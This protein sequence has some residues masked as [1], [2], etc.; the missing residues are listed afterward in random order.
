MLR[1]A[2]ASPAMLT[3]ARAVTARIRA[4]MWGLPC[5]VLADCLRCVVT[6]PPGWDARSV[7][8]EPLG[9]KCQ[10][11]IK[12]IADRYGGNGRQ[13]EHPWMSQARGWP[14]ASNA[15]PSDARFERVS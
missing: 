7:W 11:D 3:V 2:K 12:F 9:R 10:A 5:K 15:R 8:R 6:H 1:C 14:T 4:R 13:R